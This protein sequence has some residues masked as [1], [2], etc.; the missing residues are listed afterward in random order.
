MNAVPRPGLL[1]DYRHPLLWLT[2]YAVMIAVVV[3]A[4]LMPA[5]NLPPPPFAG[6]DKV[7]HFL[8]Y[9]ALSI[10]AVML[11]ARMRAQALSAAALIALGVALEFVQASMSND[12]AG[13]S[14][15]ALANTLGV[16]AGLLTAHTPLARLLLGV[17][18][19]WMAARR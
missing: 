5:Q 2:V 8:A 15:D 19:R 9:A 1:R 13:D 17:E 6:V 3:T 11:F 10:Y 4:S 14:A 12:R 18:R 7:E 16:L